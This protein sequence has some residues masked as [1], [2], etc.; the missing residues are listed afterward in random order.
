[1]QFWISSKIMSLFI[2]I[3]I[4][5]LK[6]WNNRIM[7]TFFWTFKALLHP[8]LYLEFSQGFLLCLQQSRNFVLSCLFFI[9]V[10]TKTS[11]KYTRGIINMFS[12]PKLLEQTMTCWVHYPNASSINYPSINLAIFTNGFTQ[13][14]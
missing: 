10:K 3:Y 4:G 5:S 13:L 6:L 14:S 9:H 12:E 8:L 1:M 11:G 2:H 7:L